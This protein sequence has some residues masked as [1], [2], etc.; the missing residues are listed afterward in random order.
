MFKECL[1]DIS[2]IVIIIII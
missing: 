2:H 1:R